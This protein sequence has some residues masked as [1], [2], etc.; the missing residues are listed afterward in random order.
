MINSDIFL[1]FVQ[2]IDSMLKYTQST[3]E[4]KIWKKHTPIHPSF[5]WKSD[6]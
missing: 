5:V 2:N 1:V 6:V 4:L 3:F